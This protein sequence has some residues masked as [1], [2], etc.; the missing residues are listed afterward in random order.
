VRIV[1]LCPSVTE[2]LFDLGC[3]SDLVA[4]TDYCVHPAEAVEAIEKIG[5]TKTPRIESIVALRPDLVLLNREENRRAD[6]AELAAHGIPCHTSM[7]TSIEGTIDM[8][9]SIGRAVGRVPEAEEIAGA[10]AERLRVAQ[11][12][13][14]RR[15]S[16]SFAYLIWRQPWMTVSADTY[17][18]A[19]LT[20]AG[21]RNVFAEA[22]DRYPQLSVDELA[23]AAPD[24]V[25]LGSEPFP[26]SQRHVE[27][28]VTAT[29][30]GPARFHLVDGR[31]LS[32]HGSRTA[33]GLEYAAAL[34]DR[35]AA[36]MDA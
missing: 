12:R 23:A 7:P 25:L 17:P 35:I 31:Y 32:W 6:A 5:G 22:T 30:W 18:H 16:I 14:R 19:V 27:E 15:P 11:R 21:G 34:F 24:A 3:G 28:L 13:A 2:L 10:I 29:G 20:A 9:R 8:V 33:P 1:S 36:S 26:F 4:V